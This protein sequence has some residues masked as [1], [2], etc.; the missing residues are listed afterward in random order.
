M[1]L[2]TSVV[3]LFPFICCKIIVEDG[4]HA[5]NSKVSHV[6]NELE[7][8]QVDKLINIMIVFIIY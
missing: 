5:G 7:K 1:C 6:E 4:K 2:S 8:C 3:G